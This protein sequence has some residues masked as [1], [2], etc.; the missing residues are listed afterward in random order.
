MVPA[1]FTHSVPGE[2]HAHTAVA[3][4]AAAAAAAG[5]GG[6]AGVVTSGYHHAPA[7]DPQAAAPAPGL[8]LPDVKSAERAVRGSFRH[9]LRCQDTLVCSVE[10]AMRGAPGGTNGEEQGRLLAS[11]AELMERDRQHHAR[12]HS[13]RPMLEAALAEEEAA[14]AE[15][16]SKLGGPGDR[17]ERA[18]RDALAQQLAAGQQEVDGIK[19]ALLF[20]DILPS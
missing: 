5:S 6:V 17:G 14:L 11:I 13:L 8:K 16:T 3:A 12:S 10:S 20:L 18:A 15:V 1:P 7:A 19:G 4:A 9:W 2:G